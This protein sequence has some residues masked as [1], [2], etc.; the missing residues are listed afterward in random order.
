VISPENRRDFE[1]R[2]LRNVRQQVEYVTFSPE[3]HRE[4]EE[5]IDE[6]EHALD[7]ER[8][9]LARSANRRATIALVISVLALVVPLIIQFW[10]FWR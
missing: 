7:R 4:A 3:K 8:N 10:G 6:Q 9:A 1:Q 2:G 5:W